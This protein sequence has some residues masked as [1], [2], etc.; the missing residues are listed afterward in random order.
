MYIYVC[1][2]KRFMSIYAYVYF[3]M[4]NIS[5]FLMFLVFPYHMTKSS[6]LLDLKV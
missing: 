1:T 5:G 6:M 4:Q 2:K 3:C